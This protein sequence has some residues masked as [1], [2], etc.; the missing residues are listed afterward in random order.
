MV[1]LMDA[2]RQRR[3]VRRYTQQPIDIDVIREILSAATWAP[4][5]HNAQPWQFIV[6]TEEDSKCDLADAMGEVWLQE[7][8]TDGIPKTTRE[9]FVRASADRFSTA[10]LLIIAC[11][12]LE[13]MDT[14]PD[15]RRKGYERD[16]AMQSLG[17]AIQNL[18][19]AAHAKGL[20]ACWYCAP[21][22]CKEAA[23]EALKIPEEIEPQALITL[24]YPTEQPRA[25]PR[26][27]IDYIV[28]AE[29]WD[30]PL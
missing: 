23:R 15:E 19:L 4:S 26:K 28:S 13:D 20:G 2:I 21:A 11:L 8:E 7:L 22:F 5:A 30:K 10:P 29:E 25:P 16:L 12:T 14:Y 3:S 27:P 18:L 17:A 6:L 1:N 24:G 9:D